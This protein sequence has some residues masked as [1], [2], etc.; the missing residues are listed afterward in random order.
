MPSGYI[1]NSH[2]V[3]VGWWMDRL[4]EGL[5]F[6][7]EVAF[8]KSWDRWHKY[9][10]GEWEPGIVPVN[11]FFTM[12]R[13][14]V[15]R[16]YFRNPSVSIT[17]AKPGPLF[18]GF[19]KLLER[20]DSTLMRQ[21]RLKQELKRI[22]ADSFL[23]GTGI[24]TLGFGAVFEY[25]H[26]GFV[27][28]PRVGKQQAALEYED[29][30]I[31]NMP[32]FSRIHPRNYI[33]PDQTEV[34]RS[35]RWTAHIIERSISDIKEDPRL[36]SNRKNVGSGRFTTLGQGMRRDRHH[37]R[38]GRSIPSS[39]SLG[40]DMT[41][42]AVI[43]D[44]KLRRV[45]VLA[46]GGGTSKHLELYSGFD[47]LQGSGFPEYSLTF[48]P[49][50]EHFWGV[51]DSQILEPYQLE[52]NETRTQLMQQRRLALVKWLLRKNG[53]E[54]SEIDK[55]LSPNAG[56]VAFTNGDPRTIALLTQLGDIPQS[57]FTALEQTMRDMRDTVG[58]SRNAFG[59]FN[60][61]TADT[62]A[63]EAQIVRQ[64]S[65][66]RVD[67]RRDMIADMLVDIVEGIHNLIFRHWTSQ[68]IVEVVGPGGVPIW[69]KFTPQMLA[70]GQYHVKIDPDNSL[71]ETKQV[72][73]QKALQLYQ[74]LK[75]NP[76]I[77]PIQLTQYLL[78]ELHGTAF[79]S[80]MRALPPMNVNGPIGAQQYGDVLRQSLNQARPEELI[81]GAIGNA[82]EVSRGAPAQGAQA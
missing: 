38:K 61:Q 63:T 20:T 25:E 54:Q 45:I 73:E 79:D 51:P 39:N 66:I 78:H 65:E 26:T 4:Q 35:S 57:L 41:E 48:N 76:L 6:R 47:A 53:M 17:S 12:L 19:A 70:I 40:E 74:V 69:V 7:E 67:E 55:L 8:E 10:R 22:V 16:V 3:D 71:P 31:P 64:A 23:Y 56:A 28:A 34:H 82:V 30:V 13:T 68:E 2:K 81:K 21:M 18:M 49:D 27:Q 52:I 50:P 11:L 9:Y 29:H 62:T 43:R 14:I 42:L 15:P 37:R 5:G 1:G 33:V 44:K 58:F 77:D 72:R 60:S 24:G 80:M 36:N 32:W 59:E 75:T 46:P